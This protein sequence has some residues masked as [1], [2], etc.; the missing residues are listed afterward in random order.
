MECDYRRRLIHFPV[1]TTGAYLKLASSSWDHFGQHAID[2]YVVGHTVTMQHALFARHAPPQEQET[3]LM[4]AYAMNAFADHFLSDLFSAGHVRAP[5]KEIYQQVTPSALGSY[6]LRYMHDEDSRWGLNVLAGPGR[7][8]S[9]HTYGD[10][11]YFDAV[12]PANK[13]LVDAAVQSSV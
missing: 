4:Q 13:E 6:L 12:D 3:L 5:R 8:T 2:A 7:R 1:D 10:K 11:R 9:W